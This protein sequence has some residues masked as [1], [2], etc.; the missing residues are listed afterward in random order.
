MNKKIIIIIILLITTI[1][2]ASDQSGVWVRPK[3]INGLAKD[4]VYVEVVAV[5]KY[6]NVIENISESQE[7]DY[8]FPIIPGTYYITGEFV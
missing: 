6:K 4:N 7:K 1:A 5:S 2:Y 8:I 3:Q